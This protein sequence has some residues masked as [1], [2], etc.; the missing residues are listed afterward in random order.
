M[1]LLVGAAVAATLIVAA[2]ACGAMID[3]SYEKAL[4]HGP[5]DHSAVVLHLHGCDGHIYDLARLA[6]IGDLR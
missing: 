4:V 1:R 2:T 6:L 5:E 3:K